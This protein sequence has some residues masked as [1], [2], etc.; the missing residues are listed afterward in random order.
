MQ[1][2]LFYDIETSGLNTAFDQIL[3]FA[4]IRT[5]TRLRE[6]ERKELK[7]RLRPDII[8][9][10]HAFITHRLTRDDLMAGVSEYEA[11]VQI[12]RLVNT[13]G[14]TSIGYNNL[15]F[16][17]E[18]LRFTFYRNL[19][20]PYTHQ[21]KN[22]CSR[23]DVL[24]LSALYFIF[25]PRLINWPLSE[26]KYSLKL[27]KISDANNL[28]PQGRAHQAMYDVEA[29][30]ALAG[31]FSD[32]AAVWAY[33][34]DFFNK[35]RDRERI[36]K[37]EKTLPVRDDAYAPGVIVSPAFGPAAN[38]MAP[39]VNIGHS[40]PYANQ[41]LWLRLDNDALF[42]Y[43]AVPE[44]SDFL[45]V[46][47]RYG[48]TPIILPALDR[49][50]AKMPDSVS[51]TARCNRQRIT[52]NPEDFS[53][54][55]AWHRAF[56]YPWIPRLDPDAALYQAGFFSPEEKQDIE[57]FHKQDMAG[58]RAFVDKMGTFRLKVLALRIINRNS[59]SGFFHGA[60]DFDAYMERVKSAPGDDPVKGFRNDI[61]FSLAD[62]AKELSEIEK[63]QMDRQQRRICSWLRA[64]IG[65]M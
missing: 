28:V 10:P 32:D 41:C 39:A 56:E 1:T 48:D 50:F 53:R 62:A 3:S 42:S 47:K 2:Y 22:G 54:L 29:T 52:Q 27:E 61:K 35:R 60:E 26:G 19:L 37:F 51:E 55:A 5:D 30:L 57:A 38:F 46:R 33:A 58:K 44:A 21:Y 15:G 9:S 63:G 23:M 34:L 31:I 24:P 64:Y 25:R 6:L 65:K 17:D 40:L 14:T 20:E 4:C 16:D 8:P 18:F 7:V 43:T 45:V 49:F 13:P 59:L 36:E 12:H 11:A